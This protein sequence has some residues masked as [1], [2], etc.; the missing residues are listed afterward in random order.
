MATP[1]AS[2]VPDRMRASTTAA[3]LAT[4]ALSTTVSVT[5]VHPSSSA[6]RLVPSESRGQLIR[7]TQSSR[8]LAVTAQP[9]STAIS[10][11]PATTVSPAARKPPPRQM[12]RRRHDRIVGRGPATTAVLPGAALTRWP[13]SG[14]ARARSRCRLGAVGASPTRTEHG[15]DAP[16]LLLLEH[17]VALRPVVERHHVGGEVLGPHLVAAHP[18]EDLGDVAVPVLLGAA[19]GQRLVH[20][21]AEGELV[22]EAGEDAEG[23]HRAALAAGVDRLAHRRGSVGLQPQLLLDLVVE[24]LRARMVR[25][26]AHRLDADV[27]PPATGH[28]AQLGGDV[29]LLVVEG[30]RPDVRADLLEPV[31]EPVDDHDPLGALEHGRAG[32]HLAHSPSPPDRD[33]VTRLHPGLVRPGPAG[34]CGVGGEQR[35]FVGD[36]VGNRERSLVGVGHPDV[37]RVAARPAAERV[38]V[39]ETAADGLAPQ[40]LGHPR[41]GVAVVAQRPQPL[42]AVPALP[43][44]D[45]G[46]H[47]HAVTHLVLGHRAADLGDRAHELVPE[48]VAGPHRR[49]A[50]AQTVQVRAAGHRQADLEDDVVVV[51]DLRLGDVLHADLVDP[52]PG[53]RLHRTPAFGATLVQLSRSAPPGVAVRLPCGAGS[54]ASTSPTSMSCL[55]RRSADRRSACGSLPLSR[56]AAEPDDGRS[57]SRAASSA[58]LSS[59][60]GRTRTSIR[61]PNSASGAGSCAASISDGS[62]L[63][64][65]ASHPE[66]GW[67]APAGR[68][69]DGSMTDR[70][71]PTTVPPA[72][73]ATDATFPID[74]VMLDLPRRRTAWPGRTPARCARRTPAGRRATGSS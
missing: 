52:A 46:D 18:V 50:A 71:L 13:R 63:R 28:L 32:G 65:T 41:V 26:H 59:E 49:A 29:D 4:A 37:G 36:A 24:V 10:G 66:A 14:L 42:P 12:S 51:E 11:T 1:T 38:G 34:G 17:P 9:T 45:E 56:W 40:R 22:H 3:R 6:S 15:T 25:L 57:R 72:R 73:A 31:V 5:W 8:P 67:P 61:L 7:H 39:P 47:H 35:P 2:P 48:H 55:A 60:A 21:R 53:H 44:A 20:H 16:V 54:T 43:A 62:R 70:T 58:P 19:Q 69:A 27:R 30:L 33:D 74:E 23:E 68:P 64:V